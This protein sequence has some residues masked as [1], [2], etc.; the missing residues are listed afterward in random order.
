MP[1]PCPP[2]D[3]RDLIVAGLLLL[4]PGSARAA[5]PPARRLAFSITRNGA[6]IGEHV[7]TFAGDPSAPVVTTEV[8]MSVRLGPV[9]V[10]RYRHHAV[11]RWSAGRFQSLETATDSNGKPQTVSAHRDVGGLVIETAR[12]RT[13]GPADAAPLTHWNPDAFATP[14]FNPQE[15]RM[16]KVQ[17]SRPGP[18]HWTVRGEAEID[19]FYDPDGVWR[20]LKGRLKDGSTLEY[21][22]T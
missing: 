10:Y 11:E 7:M 12:G 20:A 15:G 2:M 3:R 8:A 16:L 9:P 22:R 21:R 14:L 5:L 1:E 19:D 17:V 6:H 13:V 18:G 4:F